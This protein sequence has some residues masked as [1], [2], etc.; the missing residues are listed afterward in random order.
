MTNPH[1]LA[2]AL[3]LGLL[4]PAMAA[5]EAPKAAWEAGAAREGL[6]RGLPG[7]RENWISGE[8]KS[9]RGSALH[10][11]LRETERYRL[12]DQEAHLGGIAPLTADTQ[13]QIEA[14]AS[15]SHRV[16]PAHYLALQLYHRLAPGWSLNAGLRRSA[17]DSGATRVAHFG[18]D[19][20]FSAER[21]SYTLYE[22]G[23][24]GSGRS[25]SHRLQWA[26]SYGDRDWIGLSLVRGRET[27]HAGNAGFLT[28]RV[29]AASLGGRHGFAPAWALIW[30]IGTQRQGDLYTRRGAR[31][32][33]RHDF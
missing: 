5:E 21:L 3:C 2:L 6:S 16:L 9:A 27:E 12:V 31:L 10:G 18:A 20:Y 22:G 4:A 19:R 13:A 11:G 32:G 14:G 1:W 25:P 17:Y 15:D 33:L 28:T 7:W 26:H 30:D 24:D 8:W 29:R 23:P